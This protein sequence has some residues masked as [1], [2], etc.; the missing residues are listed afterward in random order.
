MKKLLLLSV[1]LMFVFTISNAQTT[2]MQI[3][4]MDC[5]GINHDLFAE[6]D[7]GK[8]VILHFFMPNCTTCPP[9]ALEIQ[10][11]A[12]NIMATYPGMI[13]GYA[14]PFQNSTTCEYTSSWVS[15]S[16]LSL[17]APY[18]SGAIQVAYY[19]G[20]GMPTVVLLGGKNHEILFST[21]SFSTSDTTFMR[22][23]ILKL[24]SPSSVEEFPS[25]VTSFSISPNPAGN[26]ASIT[27]ELKEASDVVMDIVDISGKKVAEIF[28][29]K[30]SGV[31]IKQFNTTALPTGNYFVRL[32]VNGKYFIQKLSIVH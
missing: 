20:F 8:A 30:L 31:E 15:S 4:G 28:G 13:T 16:G 18:D 32:Q 19:G 5:N 12:N 24:L 3:N 6:L 26:I 1:A 17:Y 23:Q 27:L 21:L 2:A 11:M 14:L 25:E 22:D 7:A 29:E 9:P 10:A